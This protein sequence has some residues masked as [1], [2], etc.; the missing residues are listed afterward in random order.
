MLFTTFIFCKACF[1]NVSLVTQRW[2]CSSSHAPFRQSNALLQKKTQFCVKSTHDYSITLRKS[3]INVEADVFFWMYSMMCKALKE[4]YFIFFTKRYN[5]SVIH[6]DHVNTGFWQNSV[7]WGEKISK[8][9]SLQK[10]YKQIRSYYSK[11]KWVLP[12]TCFQELL[13]Y[14]HIK[15]KNKCNFVSVWM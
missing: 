10:Y 9:N 7:I 11:Y 14:V 15:C 5:E 12:F 2:H 1:S 6:E 8:L 4:F 13:A 3:S